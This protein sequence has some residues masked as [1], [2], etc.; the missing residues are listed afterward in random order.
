[1]TAPWPDHE[2]SSPPLGMHPAMLAS[3]QAP[4]PSPRREGLGLAGA[5]VA[6]AIVVLTGLVGFQQW[7]NGGD[8]AAAETT[9][10]VETEAET[11]ADAEAASRIESESDEVAEDDQGVPEGGGTGNEADGGAVPEREGAEGDVEP[12]AC[13]AQY[14]PVICDAAAFVQQERGRPFKEFPT[15]ELLADAEFDQEL[16]ADFDE[17]RED[18][19]EDERVLKALGLM[20]TD[21]DLVDAFR[22]LLESGV[23]GFYDPETDRL[24]VRGAEFDLFSQMVLVHELV[25]AFDDQWFDLDRPD[26]AN[27]DQEYGFIAVVEGNASRIEDRWRNRLSPEDQEEL[28]ALEFGSLSLEDLDRLRRLPPVILQLQAS[29]YVDG[30]RYVERMAEVGGEKAVDDSLAVAPVS[31]EE[32]LHLGGL[33][34]DDLA[35]A[36]LAD[37]STGGPALSDGTLGELMLRLWLDEQAAA[38]WGGDRYVV[39]ADTGRTCLTVDLAAD[40]PT[41]LV[42]MEAAVGRWREQSPDQR[43]A[44]T[45]AGADR[46]II[47]ATGCY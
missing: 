38:G 24:V 2:P 33:F 18:L 21:V 30:Q 41:D 28:S 8:E 7:R 13:P 16:L 5:A 29:P 17:Y 26:Y 12:V 39:W 11:E 40:T 10:A 3:E 9:A 20:P 15:I 43:T 25:H 46:T 34:A 44:T 6:G 35:I 36:D 37:P 27:D 23:L 1:M 42:E 22:S 45:V 47:R 32:V 14:D 31:S 19:V 4:S